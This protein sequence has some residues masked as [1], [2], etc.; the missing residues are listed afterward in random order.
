MGSGRGEAGVSSAGLRGVEALDAGRCV[1][2]GDT[3][4][5]GTW[6]PSAVPKV[7]AGGR[8]LAGLFVKAGF[9]TSFG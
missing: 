9:W 6:S 5:G 3:G 8:I 2:A 1:R 4:L 7:K